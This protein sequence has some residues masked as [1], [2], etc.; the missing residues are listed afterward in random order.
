MITEYGITHA[1]RPPVMYAAEL[2]QAKFGTGSISR[3]SSQDVVMESM[4][5]GRP[6]AV[7]TERVHSPITGGAKH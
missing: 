5:T 2:V 7:R 4:D 6:K 1:V 3:G